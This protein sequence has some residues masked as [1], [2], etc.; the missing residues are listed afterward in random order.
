MAGI[1]PATKNIPLGLAASLAQN[2]I[3]LSV[4]PLNILP[5]FPLNSRILP[6]ALQRPGVLRSFPLFNPATESFQDVDLWQAFPCYDLW[7]EPLCVCRR[8]RRR[9]S[10]SA[11]AIERSSS[12]L[13]I[14]ISRASSLALLT[15][16]FSSAAAVL[17]RVTLP[18]RYVPF[19]PHFVLLLNVSI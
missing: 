17:A 5:L 15:S 19:P 11:S 9:V 4:R 6:V 7:R 3:N 12:V 13:L 16:R 1:Y 2:Y 10:S 18:P 8:H 14:H